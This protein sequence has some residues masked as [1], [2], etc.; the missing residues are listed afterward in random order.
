MKNYSIFPRGICLALLFISMFVSNPAFA[1]FI[2]S[3]ESSCHGNDTYSYHFSGTAFSPDYTVKVSETAF[4][5]DITMK[6]VSD[7]R[8]ADL[9]FVDGYDKSDM[10]VCKKSSS[11]G[12]KTIKVSETAFSPDITVKLSETPLSPDYK[13]FVL[14]EIFTKEEAVALFAVI[15]K[16]NRN[17]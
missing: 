3:G 17:K 6:I 5:P 12:V 1:V 15:W 7:P 11:F 16:A 14:S 2:I 9:I 8:E 10:K 4:S 13:I